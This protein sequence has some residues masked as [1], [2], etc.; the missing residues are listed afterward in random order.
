MLAALATAV[1]FS[2]S[3]ATR[4]PRSSEEPPTG[5]G[6]IYLD[7][8]LQQKGVCRHRSFAFL[9][10][11]LYLGIPTRMIANEAHA[12]V[13]VDDLRPLRKFI[14]G[15]RSTPGEQ[16]TVHYL[17]PQRVEIEARLEKP[18]L[19]ILADVFYSGWK[20]QIDGHEAPLL[21]VNGMMRLAET[22]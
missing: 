12:W 18:G 3:R 9:V 21:R 16:V 15:G 19:V 17:N 14:A 22:C 11:A 2:M 1:H 6:D 13:E 4:R 8:A 10:T 20:L 5:R 7:L